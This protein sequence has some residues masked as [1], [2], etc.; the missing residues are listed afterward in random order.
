MCCGA[1]RWGPS[2]PKRTTWFANFAYCRPCIRISRPRPKFTCC[3]KI[4]PSSARRFSDAAPARHRPARSHSARNRRARKL[5]A[6]ISRAFTDC[7]I[8]MHAVDVEKHGLLTLGKPEG[9][10][11]RQVKGWSERWMRAQTEPSPEMDRV[12]KWLAATIPPSGNATLVHNDFKLDNVMLDDG[13][14]DRIEAV[15]DWEMTTVGDPLCDLGLTLCYW[16]STDGSGHGSPRRSPRG[17]AGTRAKNWSARYAERTGRDLSR[18]ALARSIRRVQTRR[19]PAADLLPFLARPNRTTNVFAHFDQR[20][21]R[22][23]RASRA[24]DGADRLSV[25]YLVR[26]GQAGTRENYDSLSDLGRDRPVCSA[27][28]SRARKIRFDAVYSGALS[29]QQ[30]DRGGERCPRSRNHRRSRMERVRSWR[31]STPSMRRI[32]PPT[33]PI[34]AANTKRCRPRLIA[35]QGAHD[36]PVHRRWN[37]CD[38]KVVRAWVEGRYHY[39]GE[40][41]PAFFA[42]IHAALARIAGRIHDGNAIVFTSATPIGVCAA[43][44]LEISDG[45]A[46]WLAAVL[47]NA[48]FSTLRVRARRNPPVQLQCR[49]APARA[50]ALRTFR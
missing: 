18:S 4:P 41:W 21:Q 15:L 42:R 17:P 10:V 38:K 24:N 7:L 37:D 13:S 48:S 35:S 26:H 44:T 9:F 11:A 47:L 30:R 1:R 31:R 12:M 32:W 43:R 27:N 14:P 46:M 39:S 19:D 34:F 29:R 5:P 33:T 50:P 16:S 28:I 36:A 2:L 6:R 20:V 22:V 40:S 45:R 49:A 23:D 8:Q 3:A 25:L